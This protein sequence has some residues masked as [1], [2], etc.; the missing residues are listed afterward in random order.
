[1]YFRRLN[2]KIPSCLHLPRKIDYSVGELSLN[3]INELFNEFIDQANELQRIVKKHGFEDNKQINLFKQYKE[4][5]WKFTL[6]VQTLH[7]ICFEYNGNIS[8]F[9]KCAKNIRVKRRWFFDF[10]KKICKIISYKT[11]NFRQ[12]FFKSRRPRRIKLVYPLFVRKMIC[13]FWFWYLKAEHR[14]FMNFTNLWLKLCNKEVLSKLWDFS[15][16]STTTLRNILNEDVRTKL[17][18]KLVL[19]KDHPFRNQIKQ[20]GQLQLDFKVFGRKQTGTGKYVYCLDCIETQ[21]RIPY[22]KVFR[23]ATVEAVMKELNKIIKF[24]RNLEI[25]INTIR[26][27]NAMM[28]KQTNFVYSSEFN[29]WCLNNHIQ[30]EFTPLGEPQ[31]DGCVERYHKTLDDEVVK[32]LQDLKE[33][34]D[35]N[36][37]IQD[38]VNYF[39]NGRYFHYCELKHLPKKQ[40][41]MKP[42][43]AIQY[44][45]S[46][47]ASI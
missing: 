32:F 44:F 22:S 6:F 9:F 7:R 19:V 4:F 42:I 16:L 35:I 10:K 12:F 38:Y 21:T 5:Y 1:M 3:L 47:N 46:Y 27:D 18:K 20:L 43:N 40:Q 45:K 30:H 31:C 24:Y 13:S 25:E 36:N 28:F 39:I 8:A 11:N 14:A 29:V 17:V 2:F 33:L 34:E 23:I 37:T 15:K 26:T 41:Y